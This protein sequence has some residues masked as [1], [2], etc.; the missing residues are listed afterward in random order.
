MHDKRDCA[1]VIK[2]RILRWGDYPELPGGPSGITWVLI[3]KQ[4]GQSKRRGD[5]EV[6]TE[7]RWSCAKEQGQFLEAR[8]GK[9]TDSP[10]QC[11]EEQFC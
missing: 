2:L 8:K 10:L 6:E 3:R 1:T 9:E 5:R 4:E 7:V 11:P